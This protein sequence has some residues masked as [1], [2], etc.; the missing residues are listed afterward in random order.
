MNNVNYDIACDVSSCK[1]N[2]NS[3]N[4]TLQKIQV[5]CTHERSVCTCCE[6]YAQKI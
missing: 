2:Y 4:C 1:Y 6:S 5:G 3:C